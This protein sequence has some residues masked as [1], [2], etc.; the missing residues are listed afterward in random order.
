[1][2]N[3]ENKKLF[4]D[5]LSG[6]QR[7]G[8]DKLLAWLA[9]KSDFYTA[10]ASTRFHLA[11]EGGLLQHSLNVYT[12]AMK[13]A[14]LY[15]TAEQLDDSL[16]Q[17]ITLCALMHDLC[18]ANTYSKYKK[19]VKNDETGR[20]EAVDAYKTDVQVPWG[21]SQK[22][23]IMLQNFVRLSGD[24]IGAILAHMG[25]SDSAFKGGDGYVGDIFEKNTLA[26]VIH[27]A[28]LAASKII[29]RGM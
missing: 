24:E 28:D 17:S 11:C 20:W 14:P 27:M 15:F 7:E 9:T 2:N 3:E 18:K 16:M 12:E 8:I 25:F 13:L 26:V 21:H 22:S 5:L 4:I 10:P 1:M 6:V 19:N 29:E 23:V